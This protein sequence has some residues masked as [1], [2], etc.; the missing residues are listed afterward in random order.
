MRWGGMAQE[1][2]KTVNS[3]D[4]IVDG[5]EDIAENDDRISIRSVIEEFG[6]RSFG[7]FILILSLIGLLPTGG[8]PGVPSFVA[9]SIA[10]VAGQIV[11]G[12][13]HIWVPGFIADRS[14][15][16]DKLSGAT[17]KLEAIASRLDSVTGKRL[18]W[19]S[20]GMGL[21]VVAA[22][23]VLIC[24]AVPPLE[25]LPF[26]AAV[27]FALI[28]ALSLAMIVRDGLVIAIAVGLALVVAGFGAF[29]ALG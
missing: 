22:L 13:S 27:P 19:L 28:A 10:L 25:L 3:V 18:T 6:D 4:D 1:E 23:I 17:G 21:R 2:S 29:W 11:F 14:V 5:L 20:E 24:V 8:I 15:P 9:I 16:S 7:P 26:A 12:R